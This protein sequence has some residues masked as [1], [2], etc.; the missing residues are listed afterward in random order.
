MTPITLLQTH[1]FFMMKFLDIFLFSYIIYWFFS[2]I[3]CRVFVY[4]GDYEEGEKV[5][6]LP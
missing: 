1:A 6:R 4:L 5:I 3:I 2:F